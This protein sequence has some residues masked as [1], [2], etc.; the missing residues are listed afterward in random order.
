MILAHHA[1]LRDIAAPRLAQRRR[2][3][4]GSILLLHGVPGTG[5]TELARLIAEALRADAGV[6]GLCRRAPASERRLLRTERPARAHAGQPPPS[7]S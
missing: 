6:A 1:R 4:A 2:A 7:S 3:A 5:K